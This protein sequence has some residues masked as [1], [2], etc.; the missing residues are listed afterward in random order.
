MLGCPAL[1]SHSFPILLRIKELELVL[2][3]CWSES[4]FQR[5]NQSDQPDLTPDKVFR[6]WVSQNQ[7]IFSCACLYDSF[8][9]EVPFNNNTTFSSLTYLSLSNY[10]FKYS[11]NSALK[12]TACPETQ[13]EE[14]VLAILYFFWTWVLKSSNL[15]GS[16]SCLHSTVCCICFG[17]VS[18]FLKSCSYYSQVFY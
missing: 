8:L 16:S 12:I 18:A 9:K 7:H 15:V 1:L 10:F 11:V 5:Q 14:N 4:D 2:H 13:S 17:L 6:W 3:S